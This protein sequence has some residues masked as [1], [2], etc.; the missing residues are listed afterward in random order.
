MN[1]G[2]DV[3]AQTK[4]ERYKIQNDYHRKTGYAAQKRYK[5]N[6]GKCY[7]YLKQEYKEKLEEIA[8]EKG[9]SLSRLFLDAAEKFYDIELS[10]KS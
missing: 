10:E 1:V 6:I 5:K 7:I 3:V 2:G 4:E 8:R 9:V